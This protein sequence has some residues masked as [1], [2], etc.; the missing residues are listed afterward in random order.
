MVGQ[1]GGLSL[2]F[3]HFQVGWMGLWGGPPGPQPAPWPARESK[4]FV[5]GDR[6][7]DH[8]RTGPWY[9]SP[10]S[11]STLS[12]SARISLGDHPYLEEN[13]VRMGLAE[14]AERYPWARCW[15]G[16]AGRG[17]GCGPQGGRPIGANLRT[18][19]AENVS[20]IRPIMAFWL[21]ARG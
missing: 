12:C 8:A 18:F 13:S 17:A 21:S 5:T 16:E 6:L 11:S 3:V 15:A 9:R 10:H 1:A 14:E 19:S 7:L 20:I 2:E 4:A